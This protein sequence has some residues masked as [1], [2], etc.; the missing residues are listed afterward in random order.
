MITKCSAKLFFRSRNLSIFN[1]FQFSTVENEFERNYAI[2]GPKKVDWKALYA[3]YRPKV[4][5]QTTND[6]LFDIMSSMLGHLNDNHVRLISEK[7][8]RVYMAG[9][10]N[11]ILKEKNFK[12]MAEARQFL[13]QRP[14]D[15]KYIKSE[16]QER[17]DGVFSFGWV[18]GG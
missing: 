6:E 12:D 2:F 13:G 18:A 10:L 1:S 3:V 9:I 11:E 14:V 15:P 17:M 16:L 7:P 8:P 5:A 4:T